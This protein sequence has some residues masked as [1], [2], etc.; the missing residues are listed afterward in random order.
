MA[1]VMSQAL[2]HEPQFLG[3]FAATSR[4][5]SSRAGRSRDDRL[6]NPSKALAALA[7][8]F[9]V[10]RGAGCRRRLRRCA[11]RSRRPSRCRSPGR[12]A[13]SSRP[14]PQGFP[15]SH[16]V[17]RPPLRNRRHQR[18]PHQAWPC[19]RPR[20]LPHPASCPR[21]R[22][23]RH[24]RRTCLPDYPADAGHRRCK[25]TPS[26]CTRCGGPGPKRDQRCR[27]HSPSY[28]TVSLARTSQVADATCRITCSTGV[29]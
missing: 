3:S 26:R 1:L 22:C 2:P 28:R 15:D 21:H 10:R 24:R 11:R 23:I 27:R 9:R 8:G 18:R 13:G 7:D 12:S 6:G 4:S 20:A 25:H 19:W 5:R 14:C 29:E 17:P 16:R